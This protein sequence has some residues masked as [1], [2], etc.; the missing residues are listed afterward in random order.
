MLCVKLKLILVVDFKLQKS[1]FQYRKTPHSATHQSP[2]MMFSGRDIRTRL[3]L[4]RPN[5]TPLENVTYSL[6][7]QFDVASEIKQPNLI[8]QIQKGNGCSGQFYEK[9]DGLIIK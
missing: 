4:L 7:R 6:V 2:V 5:E 9:K 8:F 3:D 1:L